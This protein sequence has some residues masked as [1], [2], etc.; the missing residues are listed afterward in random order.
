MK[1]KGRG[2]SGGDCGALKGVVVGHQNPLKRYRWGQQGCPF[3][4]VWN[5]GHLPYLEQVGSGAKRWQFLLIP[6]R[7]LFPMGA[8]PHSMSCQMQY[9]YAWCTP[10]IHP[11]M[12]THVGF[13]YKVNQTRQDVVTYFLHCSTFLTNLFSLFPIC[14]CVNSFNLILV[15]HLIL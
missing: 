14:N 2:R 7:D 11:Y 3:S 12:I 10:L 9:V 1:A 13:G 6:F 8:M 15:K 5:H 4:L